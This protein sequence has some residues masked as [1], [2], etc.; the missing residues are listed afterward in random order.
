[1]NL[2]IFNCRTSYLRGEAI[3]EFHSFHASAKA[4]ARKEIYLFELQFTMNLPILQLRN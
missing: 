3:K 2:P 4:S 1:M